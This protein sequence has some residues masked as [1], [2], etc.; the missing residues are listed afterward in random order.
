[1]NLAR[2][3]LKKEK[4]SSSLPHKIACIARLSV[5]RAGEYHVVDIVAEI[6]LLHI[7]E[8]VVGKHG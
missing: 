4:K 8:I 7:G 6:V 3:K 2:I 1:L 5:E